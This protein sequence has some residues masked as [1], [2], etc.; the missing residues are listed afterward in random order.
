MMMDGTNPFDDP[1]IAGG[2]ED[3]YSTVGR[4]A[5]RREKALLAELLAWLPEA[6]SLLEVG[7]GTGHFTRWLGSLRPRTIGLDVSRT[8]LREAK[9]EGLPIGLQ[10]DG[11]A[12]PL[13]SGSVDVVSLI[14]TLA[15]LADP[16]RALKEACR[17]GRKGLLLGVI[18]RQSLLGNQLRRAKTAPWNLARLLD[19][20]QLEALVNGSVTGSPEI[21]WRTT[22]WPGLPW[23]LPVPWGGFIGMAVRLR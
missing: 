10:A 20:T 15:F 8:M 21:H 22:L 6:D 12:L 17:V 5:D 13:A 18:N 9:S 19:L 1:A 11:H 7:C 14:A 16:A 3:W 4:R 2:Y 23:S